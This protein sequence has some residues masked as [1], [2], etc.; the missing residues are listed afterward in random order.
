M[1]WQDLRN[2][3]NY[4]YA[5]ITFQGIFDRSYSLSFNV[6]YNIDDQGYAFNPGMSYY[7][8]QDTTFSLSAEIF[9]GSSGSEFGS[10]YQ[11]WSVNANITV[12]Y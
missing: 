5:G 10:L 2:S 12:S 6:I 9:S 7:F 8:N 4:F 3:K 11:L 1:Q